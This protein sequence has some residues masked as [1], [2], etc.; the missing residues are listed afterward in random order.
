M[1]CKITYCVPG[2]LRQTSVEVG[3]YDKEDAYKMA[4]RAAVMKHNITS[5]DVLN[6]EYFG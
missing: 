3:S 1:W 6:V 5:D 2:T 4:Y